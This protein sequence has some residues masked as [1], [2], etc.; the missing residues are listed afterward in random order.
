[1]SLFKLFTNPELISA[2]AN[3]NAFLD[4]TGNGIIFFDQNLQASH[5]SKTAVRLYEEHQAEFM[6]VAPAFNIKNIAGVRLEAFKLIPEKAIED[7]AKNKKW[8]KMLSL[9]DEKCHVTLTPL[10]DNLKNFK[11]AMMEFWWA[12]EYQELEEISSIRSSIVREISVPIITCDINRIIKTINPAA[13]N[14]LSQ[15]K[16]EMAKLFPGFEPEHLIGRNIDDFHKDS[17]MQ[18][19]IFEHLNVQEPYQAR[20]KLLS[21]VF[22]L[23][24]FPLRN[25]QDKIIGYAVEWLDAT[26]KVSSVEEIQRITQEIVHGNLKQRIDTYLYQGDYLH[27]VDGFNKAIDAV[28]EPLYVAADYVDKISK[29][30]IP[31]KITDTYYGDFNTIKNNL[32]NCIDA[33]SNMVAEAANLEKA[34]IEGRLATRAD[35]SQYEGDYRKIVQ[36]VNNTLDAV[37]KPLN[38]T[39]DYVNQIAKGVIPPTITDNY[40]GE[41]NIIKN[42]LNDVV[43]M[44]SDLL[45]QTDIII[46]AAADGELDKRADASLF[47]GG[48]N[49]LVAGVNDTITNIV[50]PLNVTADYVDQIAKGVIPPV[51]TAEY[52]GQYNIIK[53]N[54]NA[55]VKMMND[56][57]A[58]TDIIIKAAADGELD[59][60]ADAS[61]FVGGW[62]KL[63]AGVN[64][65]ITNIV[66]PLNVT[67]DYVDQIAKGV[68][69]PV[70]TA[71]Y[72]GQYNI[73]KGNLNA[74]VKMMNDLLAQTDIIIKAAADGDL[75]KRADASLFV[76]GWNKLVSGVNDTISNI[77][78]PLNV[79][80]DYVDQI[81][82]GVIPPVITAEYKGQYNI[83]KGNLNA[84][85]KM[86]NDLLAQ[87]DIIIKAA[88]DGELD[89][90]A[91]ASL[92]VGGWNKLVSGVNDTISNIVNPLNVTADYV[93]QISKGV[94][95]P[96]ITAEY[97]GQYNIIKGN[98]NAAVKMMNDLLAQTDII[99]KAA[100]DGALDKRAD[101]SLFVGGWNQLVKGVNQTLDGVIVPLN[102]AGDILRRVEQGDLTK[103][104]TGDYHGQLGEFKDTVN[105]TISKLSE[106]ISEV[107]SSA[108]QLGNASEQ[109]SSTSQ[110]LSQSSSE[111]AAS[112]E[113]TSASIEQMAASIN[114][115]AEN[116]KVTD[117][118]AG[119]ASKEATEGGVAVKQTV[120]AMKDIAKRIGIIDD[121]AYQ[122]NMLALNAAIEAARAGEH[123]KGF[124]VVAAEVRKLAERSQVAAQEIGELAETSVKTA[125]SAGR[126]LDEIVPSISR[127]SDLVQEIAAASQEQSSGVSQ[128]NSAMNQMN[129]IT[130]QN[131]SASEELAATA[132]EMTSQV[133]QLQNL[134]SFFKIAGNTSSQIRSTPKYSNKPEK[135]KSTKHASQYSTE[136]EFDLN[137]FE[138]F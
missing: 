7:L 105:N 121:I 103:F 6:A 80:A 26:H 35:A 65:T 101:A 134:M 12:T 138:R 23:T 32:N 69:P 36:G 63:V 79:T 45:A 17:A 28:V 44:M 99:I 16:S 92:F 97:K 76:G 78:N 51:I 74:A 107:V 10:F 29:G 53:G 18:K 67:A 117:G 132:E 114:Q 96:V 75:D 90:R 21:L 113:E 118:M 122:T 85:V 13:V 56:L 41:F 9:G 82:K 38:V 64:D 87:T 81:A 137:K 83:I 127:T 55:A 1:M 130:Q 104:V 71:E 112:V 14:L 50:N 93:D 89:K 70:I 33:I 2:A 131:A 54:L 62:N 42:N 73:I 43:K 22:D 48:W 52:K 58:Q 108:V 106:T 110:S 27:I 128:V 4:N 84:A 3:F 47:V 61:L 94:I 135:S 8:L 15:Y 37:I 133:E 115:N 123:G 11:G 116:A 109:I 57:L 46:K 66:N 24:V 68:I 129:Q 40:N 88:A 39:A 126:L 86:M 25:T 19:K 59:K 30:N 111:Q 102:E 20:I 49:K 72:K 31:E 5:A 100:A 60:R 120:G 95:P 119:K 124:A 125:E 136:S 98:L 91:D 77:V 34:A